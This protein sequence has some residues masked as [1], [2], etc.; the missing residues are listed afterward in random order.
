MGQNRSRTIFTDD[1]RTEGRLFDSGDMNMFE[2]S[3]ERA[4]RQRKTNK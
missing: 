4:S 3:R 2:G 1:G